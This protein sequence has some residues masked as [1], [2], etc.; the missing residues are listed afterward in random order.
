M[1]S[2]NNRSLLTDA[3]APPPGMVFDCGTAT[4]YSLDMTTILSLPL[5]LT[6][7]AS[8]DE[9]DP[10][11]DPVRL[12]ESLRRVVSRFTVFHEVGRLMAPSAP[13]KLYGML[14]Q[15]L[16]PCEAPGGG[17][18][19]PKVM[20]LRFTDVEDGAPP[21]LRLLVMSRNLTCDQSWDLVVRLDGQPGGRKDKRS[22]SIVDL[23]G[24]AREC[25]DKALT[26]DRQSQYARLMDDVAG[27]EWHLPPGFDEF[28]FHTLGNGN[29]AWNLPRSDRLAVISPFLGNE[30]I[31][32][33]HASTQELELVLA[34]QEELD[35]LR[36][37]TRALAH[38]LWV[39]DEAADGEAQE[40]EDALE[41]YGLH[42]KCYLQQRGHR[43]HLLIGSANATDRIH[44]RSAAYRNVE[45][46]AEL[47]GDTA[48]VGGL[49]QLMDE[50]GLGG[51]RRV[52]QY[53]D[54]EIDDD[55]IAVERRL[56]AARKALAHADLYLCCEA[57]SPE[58]RTRLLSKALLPEQLTDISIRAWPLSLGP[59][60]AVT[61]VQN[62]QGV[63]CQL[64]LLASSDITALVGFELELNDQRIRFGLELPLEGGPADR[65]SAIFRVIIEN[66]GAFIRYL[67]MLLAEIGGESGMVGGL[68][69]VGGGTSDIP[70]HVNLPLF[71][72]LA[73]AFAH[74]A[75]SLDAVASVMRR[76]DQA[77]N[78]DVIPREFRDMWEIF[79][80]AL[81]QER[82]DD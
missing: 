47:S 79:E 40:S 26:A 56:D 10:L 52:Y 37:D 73:K 61:L 28:A 51:V 81:M 8:G 62:E 23:F 67:M 41:A 58:W 6:L 57:E 36:T 72:Q 70:W 9:S 1:L 35:N 68:K 55:A 45:F 20:L 31:R 48:Q 34:R 44:A 18:F 74:N 27:C 63:N 78:Q 25:S 69:A 29:R 24:I 2:P 7:L 71:E 77:D 15:V 22:S 17:A 80:A 43:T 30:A 19:H 4:T 5:H 49:E 75:S 39:L 76:L 14:E 50:A 21:M 3:L 38:N 46:M 64:G 16:H 32:Q 33:I 66:R 11:A 59:K 54:P 82:E 65:E 12:L 60:H 42:A 13:N 53:I